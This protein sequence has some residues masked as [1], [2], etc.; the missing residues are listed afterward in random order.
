[1]TIKLEKISDI[2][3]FMDIATRVNGRVTLR[4]YYYVVDGKSIMGVMSLN[5][6]QPV[7]LDLEYDEYSKF[8][9]FLLSI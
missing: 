8:Q 6:M 7:I 3:E 5:W 2:Q 1:M 9:K 4:Q